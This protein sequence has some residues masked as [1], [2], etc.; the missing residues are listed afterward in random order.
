MNFNLLRIYASQLSERE[1]LV[2]IKGEMKCLRIKML[3]IGGI[4]SYKDAFDRSGNGDAW[5]AARI[6]TTS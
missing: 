5:E 3:N 2:F 6:Y 1:L 4:L